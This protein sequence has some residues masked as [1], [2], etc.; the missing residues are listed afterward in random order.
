MYE[1][2][3]TTFLRELKQKNPDIAVE[4]RKGRA[5]WWDKPQDAGT[6]ATQNGSRVPQSAY[7]YQTK[8]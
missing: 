4:Q 7:V 8:N 5:L 3:T 2:D 1:S 6:A